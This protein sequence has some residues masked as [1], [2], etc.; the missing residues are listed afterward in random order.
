MN[1]HTREKSDVFTRRTEGKKNHNDTHDIE[2]IDEDVP[3]FA[4]H[5][6]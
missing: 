4:R 6:I 3:L 5:L 1:V 2:Y